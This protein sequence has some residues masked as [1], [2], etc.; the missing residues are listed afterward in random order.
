MLTIARGGLRLLIIVIFAT[1][2]VL[3]SG[4][5]YSAHGTL[6]LDILLTI[7]LEGNLLRLVINVSVFPH[8]IVFTSRPKLVT[9]YIVHDPQAFLQKRLSL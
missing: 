1:T 8:A 3:H 9:G 4:H 5:G 6:A 7:T 2:T